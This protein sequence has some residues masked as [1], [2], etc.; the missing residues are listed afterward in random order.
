MVKYLLSGNNFFLHDAIGDFN[1][2][3]SLSDDAYG[4]KNTYRMTS[5][6]TI[7]G[8]A[9]DDIIDLTSPNTSISTAMVINGEAGSDVIWASA[10]DDTL[11]GGEG[12][13]VLF[14]GAGVDTL[15]GGSGADIFEFEKA[16]GNDVI[17]DY[18]LS[19]G[20]KL[21]FYLQA[22]DPNTISLASGNTVKWGSLS[23]T[24]EGASFS[25]LSDISAEYIVL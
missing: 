15:T 22:G 19:Q 5:I 14:G 10:G 16:S 4:R 24:F 25:G 7:N 6:E 9:G 17:K 12:N 11:N 1:S 21:K 3:L 18:K 23:L 8:G 2:S 13:D 20:D